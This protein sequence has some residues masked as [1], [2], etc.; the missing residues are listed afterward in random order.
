MGISKECLP[1]TAQGSFQTIGIY[2]ILFQL[3]VHTVR[4]AFRMAKAQI[5]TFIEPMFCWCDNFFM[6]AQ[7]ISA[8][9]ILERVRHGWVSTNII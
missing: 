1:R 7:T 9:E 3:I 2:I 6:N 5:T 4:T 8:G